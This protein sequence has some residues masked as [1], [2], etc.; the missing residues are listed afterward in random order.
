MS[1]ISNQFSEFLISCQLLI[2]KVNGKT[3][4]KLEVV[5]MGNLCLVT[6][7]DLLNNG[8]WR[9]PELPWHCHVML[10]MT[11]LLSN[12]NSGPIT[13]QFSNDTK[14]Y[15]KVHREYSQMNNSYIYYII[16]SDSEIYLLM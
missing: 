13:Q 8:N 3:S 6:H 4:R 9:L 5:F 16:Y 15:K 1:D 2:T 12:G 14:L 11:I 7:G 10:F